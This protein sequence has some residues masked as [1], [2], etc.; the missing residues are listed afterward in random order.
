MK[1][2]LKEYLI[3]LW[4]VYFCCW[5][6]GWFFIF[7]F[8]FPCFH[9]LPWSE[10]GIFLF[11]DWTAISE[12]SGPLAWVTCKHE[13]C[14]VLALPDK[15]NWSCSSWQCCLSKCYDWKGSQPFA[16]KS[17]DDSNCVKAQTVARGICNTENDTFQPNLSLF[18]LERGIWDS[19]WG[20]PSC[21]CYCFFAAWC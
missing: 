10:V 12:C 2:G 8:F 20:V 1:L 16:R 13:E 6:F 9:V 7:L 19:S 21:P 11:Q 3:V 4:W 18:L 15:W 17:Q 14:G 5:F